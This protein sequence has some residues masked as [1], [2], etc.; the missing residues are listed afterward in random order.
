VELRKAHL[1]PH[2]Q[3]T[4]LSVRGLASAY[5]GIGR[6]PEA[7]VL[8]EQLLEETR[9][10][11]G[12]DS[13][14]TV[15]LILYIAAAYRRAG[16]WQRAMQLTERVVENEEALRGPTE[17]GASA[18]AHILGMLYMDAGEYLESAAR[19]QK[20]IALRKERDGQA[21]DLVLR[22]CA[23][24]YQRAG[25]LDDADRL[26]RDLSE[27][28][29][30]KRDWI[31]QHAL[32]HTL[33]LLSLNMLLQNRPA[34]AETLAREVLAL[35]EKAQASEYEWR[36]PYV[37]NLLGGALLGQKRY[38]EAESLLLQGY[39][40]MKQGEATMTAQW[41]FRLT[42]AGERLV[43]YYEE[44]DH[45]EKAREWQKKVQEDKDKK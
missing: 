2:Y 42:E 37:I 35:C 15:D 18:S 36:R 26:L 6:Y 21:D 7:I 39:Q 33:D 25:K 34:E 20:V 16:D 10:C 1:G 12:P 28:E 29:R 45:P 32:A 9:A 30:K 13:P 40:G 5:A 19:L 3:D 31:G 38:A 4:L 44:T 14:D 22:T 23:L 24:A 17:A 27:R 43:R 11:R 8:F 41:R